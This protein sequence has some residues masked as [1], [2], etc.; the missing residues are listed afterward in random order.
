[1]PQQ[2]TRHYTRPHLH[3][4]PLRRF[5]YLLKINYVKKYTMKLLNKRI[6]NDLHLCIESRPAFV[7]FIIH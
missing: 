2:P 7:G 5:I 3:Y 6:I 1:M 4:L